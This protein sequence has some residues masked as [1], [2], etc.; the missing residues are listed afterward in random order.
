MRL[1][2]SL[3]IAAAIMLGTSSFALS[4]TAQYDY[5]SEQTLSYGPIQQ[6]RAPAKVRRHQGP[7][8][9]GPSAK[10]DDTPEQTLSYGAKVK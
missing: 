9:S 3:M 8:N 7:V 6:P 4:Q 1:K 10:Y 2:S 5:T